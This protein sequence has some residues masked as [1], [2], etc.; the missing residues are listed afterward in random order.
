MSDKLDPLYVKYCR[1]QHYRFDWARKCD[2]KELSDD[3]VTVTLTKAEGAELQIVDVNSVWDELP[4]SL[5]TTVFIAR[6][7]DRLYLVNTE[8]FSYCRYIAPVAIGEV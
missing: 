1:D 5:S 2:F 6:N 8:G 3:Y 4:E 7:N